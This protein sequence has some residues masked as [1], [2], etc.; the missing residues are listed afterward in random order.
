MRV[1]GFLFAAGVLVAG[2]IGCTSLKTS[3][4]ARSST[5][6]LLISNSVDQ[7]L[8]KVD[9]RPFAN[10]KVYL[11]EKYVDCVDKNYVIASIRHQLLHAGSQLVAKPEEAD[12]VVE[13]RAGSVGT[14]MK[15]MFLGSPAIAVPGPFP[16][17]LPE[18]KLVSRSSQVGTAKIGLV[19]Y[20]AKTKA[21]V[22]SGG[23]A[24]SQSDDNNW[25]LFGVGPFQNGSVRSELSRQRG[26]TEMGERLPNI[27]AF[28]PPEGRYDDSGRIRL[29]N[30]EREA[31]ENRQS[32]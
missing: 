23:L 1:S 15:D 20:D 14:D 21:A 31:A 30:A 22:G 4:T 12:L 32:R 7:A 18:V 5:E 19:A 10:R 24:L 25:F 28:N 8:A 13:A 27:V 17:S 3:N 29:T 2:Q 6:Q 26:Q 11:E 16:I 9:F